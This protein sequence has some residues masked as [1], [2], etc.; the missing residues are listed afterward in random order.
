MKEQGPLDSL[1][2][3]LATLPGLG[4]RSAR[5]IALHLL[6]NRDKAMNPL[7]S[8]LQDS[9]DS[10]RTCNICGNLDRTDPCRICTDARRD[11]GAICVT[12]GIADLWAIERTG[13]YKGQ[14]HVLGGVLSALDGIGPD[15]LRVDPL[16]E[17]I[18]QMPVREVIIALSA[19]V[20]GQ[21]TAHFL[22]DRLLDAIPEL[23]ITRLAHGVPVGGEL[24]YLD[25]GTIT[26]A[27]KSRAAV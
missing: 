13:A 2:K 20:N 17:R 6:C 22:T 12:A 21:T 19:T 9:K 16:L 11:G 26:T 25:D 7:I 5:R 18:R 3:S 1:I 8:A 4:P 27:L 14:Y 15:D 23:K 10:V 24:D